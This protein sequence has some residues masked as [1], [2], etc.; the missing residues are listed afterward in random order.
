MSWK[1]SARPRL[2]VNASRPLELR[3]HVGQPADDRALALFRDVIGIV[4]RGEVVDRDAGDALQRLGDRLV[5]QGADVLGADRI[6]HRIRI[7][8]D[9]NCVG[10]GAPNAGDDDRV[11]GIGTHAHRGGSGRVTGANRIARLPRR[12]CGL[13]N[14]GRHT[15][16]RIHRRAHQQH[17]DAA[18]RT[19][20]TQISHHCLPL[21]HERPEP[22]RLVIANT[23]QAGSDNASPVRGAA[24][25]FF[26]P[27][28]SVVY[29]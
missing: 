19:T 24:K 16:Q 11:G 22:D 4:D 2:A 15:R 12:L 18:S 1:L 9:R 14:R 27:R 26:R 25:R 7:A 28:R 8:L 3:V 13:R 17:R 5:G 20:V 23:R 29:R 6:D 21:A 10:V